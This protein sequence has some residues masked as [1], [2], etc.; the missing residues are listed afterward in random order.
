[1]LD[2]HAQLGGKVNVYTMN[3]RGTGRSTRLEC[4]AAQAMTSGSPRGQ[5]IVLMEVPS[6]AKDLHFKYGNLASFSTTSAALDLSTFISDYTN[7]ANTFVYE[8]RHCVGRA[9]YAPEHSQCERVHS[10]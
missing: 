5:N 9:P 8:L 6:C 2:L 4:V 7:G 1:M 3:H 10:R